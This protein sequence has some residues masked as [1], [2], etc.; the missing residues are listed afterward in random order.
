[1]LKI[2]LVSYQWY[3]NGANFD[4]HLRMAE[5]VLKCPILTFQSGAAVSCSANGAMLGGVKMGIW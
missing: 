2:C 1:M 4:L 5:Q 3:V